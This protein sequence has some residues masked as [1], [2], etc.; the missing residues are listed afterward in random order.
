MTNLPV[1][2]V[3]YRRNKLHHLFS[4]G[5]VFSPSSQLRWGDLNSAGVQSSV[6][7]G[8]LAR[9]GDDEDDVCGECGGDCGDGGGDF[10]G[11]C[12][13]G[14]CLKFVDIFRLVCL[15][16]TGTVTETLRRGLSEVSLED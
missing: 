3:S 1:P 12:G 7:S 13:A 2:N 16:C 6:S 4:I 5:N 14:N 9:S 8:L 10:G 11:D 15:L